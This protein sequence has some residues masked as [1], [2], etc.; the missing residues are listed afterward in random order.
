LI[1]YLIQ[2]TTL[3]RGRATERAA[4]HRPTIDDTRSSMSQIGAGELRAP[5]LTKKSMQEGLSPHAATRIV[6]LSGAANPLRQIGAECKIYNCRD[7][8]RSFTLPGRWCG[9]QVDCAGREASNR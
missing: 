3:M 6:S 7:Y 1:L 9:A 2:V 8:V 4:G 5:T